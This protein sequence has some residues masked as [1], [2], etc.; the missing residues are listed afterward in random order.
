[1][2]EV[3]IYS[4]GACKGNPGKGG[5]AAILIC[6][7]REKEL[8]GGMPYTTNN[9]AELTAVLQGV[10]ALQKPSRITLFTDSQCVQGWLSLG[11]KRKNV[12]VARLCQAIEAAIA[13]GGHELVETKWVKAH[14][15]DTYN[16][17]CDQLANAAVPA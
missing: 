7:K 9:Q 3:S 1:M 8:S 12:Q 11:W 16:N 6:S 2:F 4:D 13:V 5:W 14:N 17:R 15:G 10:L